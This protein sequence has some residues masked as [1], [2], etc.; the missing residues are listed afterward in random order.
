[1]FIFHSVI[2]IVLTAQRGLSTGIYF[3]TVFSN[4]ILAA[5]KR[6]F[7]RYLSCKICKVLEFIFTVHHATISILKIKIRH[8][9][10]RFWDRY[11]DVYNV[12]TEVN[13][14]PLSMPYIPSVLVCMLPIKCAV[15]TLN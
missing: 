12:L 8:C 13:K 9:T 11:F 3:S 7:K 14:V 6:V 1:V 10:L 15:W 2:Y 5:E 4:T